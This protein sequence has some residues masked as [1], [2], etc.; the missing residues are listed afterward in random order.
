MTAWRQIRSESRK[1]RGGRD[2]HGFPG[3][4]L[5]IG[6]EGNSYERLPYKNRRINLLE[7]SF[8]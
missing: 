1:R 2:F 7:K 5:P 4:L 3:N 6:L 8:S